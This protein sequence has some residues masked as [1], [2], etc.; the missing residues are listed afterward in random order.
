MIKCNRTVT[1]STSRVVYDIFVS[2]IFTSASD[3][4]DATIPRE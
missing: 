4:H 1:G 2:H 3:L